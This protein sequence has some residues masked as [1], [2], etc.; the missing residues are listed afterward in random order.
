MNSLLGWRT[1]LLKVFKFTR[2]GMVRKEDD[3]L[4]DPAY[5]LPLHCGKSSC[6]IFYYPCSRF[7]ITCV[8]NLIRLFTPVK[9]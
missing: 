3:R 6:N 4:R 7:V 1:D 9:G 5:R 2:F 8:R